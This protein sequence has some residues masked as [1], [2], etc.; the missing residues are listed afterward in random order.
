MD[1]DIFI[2]VV[3]GLLI[4]V[5]VAGIVVPVL[6]GSILILLTFLG[7][8]IGVSSGAGWWSFAFGALFAITGMSASAVLTGRR[9]K[10]RQIPNR[11]V[12]I[13]LAAGIA[14]MFV[15]PVVGLIV[16]FAGGLLISEFARQRSLS[17][18]AS[19]SWA[20]LKATGLGLL[21][22]LALALAAGTAW[23]I[24]VWVHFATR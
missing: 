2:T 6:P 15:I 11:S 12:L 4:A 10:Q 8:A 23:V 7:W 3:A 13:G 17:A 9:L 14:G 19:S 16:G 1:T 5:G 24:G 18:A 21:V 22:E 20:A